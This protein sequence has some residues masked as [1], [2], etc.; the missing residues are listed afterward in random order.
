MQNVTFDGCVTGKHVIS[1]I[2]LARALRFE[3]CYFDNVSINC[4]ALLQSAAI[5]EVADKRSGIKVQHFPQKY[6][7]VVLVCFQMR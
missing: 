2:C 1:T 5:C 3:H 6:S 4:A 7:G